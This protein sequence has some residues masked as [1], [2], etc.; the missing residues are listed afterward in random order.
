MFDP[1][2]KAGCKSCS[3]WADNYSGAI[4]HLQQRDVT[5]ITVS[6]APLEK[7]AAFKKRMG[8]TFKWVSSL[9]NDFN[10]D[11]G[12]TFTEEDR[13]K[14][15][16]DYN[17]SERDCLSPEAPGLSVFFKDK[18]GAIFH[19]CSCYARGLDMINGTYQFLDLVPS[20]RDE[21]SMEYTQARVRHH[22]RYES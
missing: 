4:I 11:F 9:E 22:D 7:I 10:R 21:A 5:L 14:G 6:R 15:K 12:V 20:G 17:Y 19:T 8:W 13:L 1:A 3:F 2:W 18:D 16:I